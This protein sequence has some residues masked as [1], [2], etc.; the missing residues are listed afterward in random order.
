[1]YTKIDKRQIFLLSSGEILVY[2]YQAFEDDSLF[3]R[4]PLKKP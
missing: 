2:K 1:M 3:D 4:K